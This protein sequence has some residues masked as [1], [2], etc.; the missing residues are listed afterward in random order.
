M[1]TYSAKSKKAK[2]QGDVS[3]LRIDA[4][5]KDAVPMAA[6]NG[7]FVVAHSETGHHHQV[8]AT[9]NLR[10]FADR[11]NPGI[12]YLVV[13]GAYADL[14][15]ARDVNKHETWRLPN[16]AKKTATI[17][18]TIRQRVWTRWGDRMVQV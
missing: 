16:I 1:K 4:L 2:H 14:E 12:C 18:K 8:K 7:V 10:C 9:A 11:S 17:Y 3:I 15:H 13:D 6:V 5:P